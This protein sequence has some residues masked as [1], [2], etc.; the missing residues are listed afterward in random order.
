MRRPLVALILFCASVV[1]LA[2]RGS[3]DGTIH[4][5]F[6][7]PIDAVSFGMESD[8][9]DLTVSG[10]LGDGTWTEW[11]RLEIEKE[12]DPLLRE[13]NLVLFP[14]PVD[15]IRVRGTTRGYDVHPIRLADE[16]VHYEVAATANV[17]K[18][19]ILSRS[20]WGADDSFL[21]RKAEE[22]STRSDVTPPQD[23]SAAP[24][25][26]RVLDC[27][28]AQRKY[29]QEF[30]T[31]NTVTMRSGERYIWP[32]SYS[33][34]VT[35]L[36]VH[37]TAMEVNGEQRSGLERMRALY[38]Y[39]AKNRGWGDIGYHY[40]ID[41]E[42][43]IYEGKAGGKYVVG[44]HAYCN[45]VGSI[46]VALMGNFSIEKPTQ[47]QMHA[48]QSL[49]HDLGNTYDIDLDAPV[50]FHG[51]RFASPIVG[52][53]D[54]LSTDCP[55]Y[56][57]DQTLA[58][59]RSNV[60]AG[61][62][63]QDVRFPVIVRNSPSTTRSLTSR[64]EQR[65]ASRARNVPVQRRVSAPKTIDVV[66]RRWQP[67]S[68]RMTSVQTP[69]QR[70]VRTAPSQGTTASSSSSEIIRIKLTASQS[71]SLR[72]SKGGTATLERSGDL[73][74]TRIGST[75]SSQAVLR[76]S[77]EEFG[78]TTLTENGRS[79]RGTIECRIVDGSLVLINELPLE[80]Y[81]SGLAE[82]PDT[83][84]FEKQRAFAVAARTYAL[85]YLDPANRKFP[86]KPYDGSDSPA[87]FQVYAGIGF[88]EKNPRWTEAVVS[89]ERQVLTK[90]GNLIKP[91]Y[92]SASDG[93]TRSPD[94]IGWKNFPFAEIFSS[95]PDPW[96]EGMGLRGHGV[97][98]SG[99]GAKAQALEGRTGE[100][101]LRYYYPGTVIT[102]G[103]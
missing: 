41:E 57:V 11:K 90:N 22:Q 99:C 92:F 10:K 21:F 44:G 67:T 51:R 23:T 61:N 102:A 75:A 33:N 4:I 96:C 47:A 17:P 43:R 42:G 56:Y 13:T 12:F 82:E 71:P 16:P 66:N 48:L 32:L 84:P 77:E 58:Q 35:L 37:H 26:Q 79:Y 81:L 30:R 62:V 86:G 100:E 80:E 45:N 1:S 95:K 54:V 3:G 60:L 46:G 88:E 9:V 78:T 5:R 24:V 91:P 68:G 69:G 87:E 98:M 40:V 73:C 25:S 83:E 15:V 85:W 59:V 34:K 31:S 101:I 6:D 64:I 20:D 36:T 50:T 2:T 94:E 53:G 89:T 74:R 49:L 63:T 103:R 19:R 28:E 72:F 93:R 8:E 55:G 29:P 97:G 65:R 38:E 39:H 7:E 27:E 70:L 18:P 52:H 76:F 14:V